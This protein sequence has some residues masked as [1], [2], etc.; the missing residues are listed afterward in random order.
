MRL[1]TRVLLAYALLGLLAGCG[2]APAPTVALTATATTSAPTKPAEIPRATVPA[3]LAT[4][5]DPA[6]PRAIMGMDLRGALLGTRSLSYAPAAG[7]VWA[8][9][10][11]SWRDIQP[12]AGDPPAYQWDAYDEWLGKL[13][14]AGLRVIATVRNNPSWASS[15]ACGPLNAA[16][17]AAFPSF[18]TALVSRY[19]QPPYNVKHWELYNEPDNADPVN[20]PELG[21]CWGKDAAGY[22]ALLQS[23][24]AAIK[25]ADPTAIVIFGGIALEKFDGSPFNVDFLKQALQAGAGSYFDWMAFHYYPAFSYRWDRYG[26]GVEGKA[27]YVRQVMKDA[28]VDKPV[29]CSE[30]GQPSAGPASEGYSQEKQSALLIQQH[31]QAILAKMPFAIWYCLQD[32][33][34][35]QR[36]YGL[37]S[38]GGKPKPA[39]ATYQRLALALNAARFER[40]LSPAE[41]GSDKIEAYLFQQPAGERKALLL[42]WRRDAG[43][44]LP[45][46]IPANSA[47]LTSSAGAQTMVSDGG[48]GDMNPAAG[49]LSVGVGP[50]PL[51][52]EY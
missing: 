40:L 8:R 35:D 5:P 6:S 32:I 48:A 4:P 18:L 49:A 26:H 45:L 50:D 41:A 25:A 43:A 46:P 17:Q 1:L 28:G 31:A 13:A 14:G 22:A 37:L 7:A 9:F 47:R 29:T 39:Y 51:I 16:G 38:A 24:Y 33:S 52:I 23:A 44:A 19:A 42:A 20:Y 11:V 21:G 34:G 10:Q 15:T 27:A 36:A 3:P 2:G 30:I 12:Q